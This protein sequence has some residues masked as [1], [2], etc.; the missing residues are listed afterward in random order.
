[1]CEEIICSSSPVYPGINHVSRSPHIN[2]HMAM[3]IWSFPKG[4]P[5]WTEKIQQKLQNNDNHE[6]SYFSS[7]KDE[8]KYLQNKT[9]KFNYQ[10]FFKMMPLIQYYPKH[11]R[12]I[13]RIPKILK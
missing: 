8:N 12:E 3:E 9:A 7:S 2:Q 1:M 13:M 10:V 4:A 11:R 5:Q 6:I